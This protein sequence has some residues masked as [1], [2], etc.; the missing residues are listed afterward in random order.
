MTIAGGRDDVR[1]AYL[2]YYNDGTDRR[3]GL[4][5][6]RLLKYVGEAA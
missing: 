1:L 6:R 5:V 3:R 2:C 4:T